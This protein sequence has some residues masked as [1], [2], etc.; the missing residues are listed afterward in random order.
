MFDIMR[1]YLKDSGDE[2]DRRSIRVHFMGD[3]SRFPKNLANALRRI[4]AQTRDNT[5]LVLNVA[6]NYSGQSDVLRATKQLVRKVSN[7]ELSVDQ[8]DHN[9]FRSHLSSTNSPLP[10]FVIRTGN[11]YRL[12][13]F[14]MWELAYSELY[15]SPKFWP[16]FT[17]TELHRA[18]ADY[19]RRQRRFGERSG[20]DELAVAS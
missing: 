8:I 12:S 17:V 13:N 5:R 2:L 19:S 6:L 20:I 18:L 10:D 4:Q 9:C 1:Q 7:G 16:E 3:L 14:M 15:F 11:E